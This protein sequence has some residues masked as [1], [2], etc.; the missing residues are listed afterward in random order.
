MDDRRH[1]WNAHIRGGFIVLMLWQGSRL[2]DTDVGRLCGISRRG[3]AKMMVN[4]E[5][6]FPLVKCADGKWQWLEVEW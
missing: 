2:S 1:D 4:L 6:W 3:A 5:S